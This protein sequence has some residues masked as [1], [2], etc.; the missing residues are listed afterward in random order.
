MLG[1]DRTT[2][3]AF[4]GRPRRFGGNGIWD[5]DAWGIYVFPGAEE[6]V[7][8]P[9]SFSVVNTV[10]PVL[11]NFLVAV[12]GTRRFPSMLWGRVSFI[13]KDGTTGFGEINGFGDGIGVE[14]DERLDREADTAWRALSW[15]IVSGV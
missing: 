14:D 9:P 3:A 11:L 7:V 1:V 6:G 13:F 2:V 5:V 15:D 10:S 8:F 4:G 12:G